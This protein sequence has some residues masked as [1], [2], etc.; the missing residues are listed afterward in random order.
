MYASFILVPQFVE[1]PSRY[2]YGFGATVT[3]AGLIMSPATIAMLLVG[4]QIGRLEKR[5]GSKPPLLAG[6]LPAFACV[7]LLPL[8][9]GVQWEIYV[10]VALLGSG[11][12]LPLSP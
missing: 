11:I 1:T 12:G 6:G 3:K 8:A 7:A 2:G 10:A 4:S 9:H 5:F